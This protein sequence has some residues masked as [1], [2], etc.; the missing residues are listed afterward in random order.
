MQISDADRSLSTRKEWLAN[1]AVS[2]IRD[3]D[4]YM[5]GTEADLPLDDALA[6]IADEPTFWIRA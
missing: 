3:M 5:K 6:F 2:K 4:R 1:A